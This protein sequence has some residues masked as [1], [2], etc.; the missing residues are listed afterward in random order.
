MATEASRRRCLRALAALGLLPGTAAFAQALKGPPLRLALAWDEA[1]AGPSAERTRCL[2]VWVLA[3]GRFE[4]AARQVVPTRAHG[5]A[6]L[7]GGELLAVARRPGL[8]LRRW[9]AD[10]RLLHEAWAEPGRQFNG[11]VLPSAD[12]RVLYSTEQTHDDGAG[13]VALRDPLTL[14]LRGEWP[15]GGTDPHQMLQVGD[16]LFVANGGVPTRPETGRAK[17]DLPAMDSSLAVFDTRNGQ[18]LGLWRL[19]DARLSLRHLA[20]HAPS[21]TLGIALQAEHDDPAE[22]ACAPLLALFDGA[23]LR[24]VPLPE[25]RADAGA[26][27]AG[28]IAATGEGF[29]L[30]AS[31]AG[32]LMGWSLQGGWRA[33]VPLAEACALAAAAPGFWALGALGGLG[34]EH[35]WTDDGAP[36]PALPAGCKPDNHALLLA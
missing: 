29:V 21:A 28:D 14:A 13:C 11:H 22:R 8:W 2:G 20:W 30:S 4:V 24:A 5:V 27:Y 15:T 32:A 36:T 19:P 6:R 23:S 26:G 10:G 34:A 18:R 16:R 17:H 35:G 25:G 7:P 33:P 12:G 31:K 9:A 1:P 3:D